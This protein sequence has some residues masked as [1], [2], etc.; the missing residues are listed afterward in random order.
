MSKLLEFIIESTK[1]GQIEK[2]TAV[3]AIKMLKAEEKKVAQDIAIIGMA[4]KLPLAGSFD[5][6]WDNI[7][8]TTDCIT[9]LPASRSRDIEAY[10]R[11]VGY[12][13]EEIKFSENAFLDEID[14]FDYR[15]FNISPKEASLMEPSQRVFLQVAWN[16]IEDAGY[17]GDMLAGTETAVFAGYASNLRDMYA[18]IIYDVDPTLASA[19]MVGNLPAVIPSRISYHLDLKGESVLLDTSCSSALVSV[20]FACRTLSEGLCEYAVAGGININTM[21][22]KSDNFKVGIESS[23]GRTR[24]FDDASDGSGIGEGVGAILLK[25]LGKALKDGDHIYAVI[26]GSA[27]NQDGSSAGITA[28]NPAA[29]TDVITKA[30][31]AAGIDPETIT[32]IETHGTGT[33][34][35]D[36]IEVKGIRG[37]FAKFTNKKQFCAISSVKTNLGHLCEAAGIISLIKAVL[38]LNKRQ[39]PPLK[40]F[41]SPNRNIDFCNSQVY[42]N[43]QTRTWEAAGETLRCGVSAFGISGTNCHVVLEEAPGQQN[44]INVD[45][46]TY[47]IFIL[48]AKSKTSLL[49]T[50]NSYLTQKSQLSHLALIDIC[51]TVA[52]GRGKYD[53]RIAIIA[54]TTDELFKKLQYAAVMIESDGL[55]SDGIYYSHSKVTSADQD[56]SIKDIGSKALDGRMTEALSIFKLNGSD[57][58]SVCD[59]C[60]YYV[61]GANAD[62][63]DFYSGRQCNRVSLPGY[64]FEKTR[65]WVNIPETVSDECENTLDDMYYSLVWRPSKDK[66]QK[67]PG[68][69]SDGG[70]TLVIKDAGGFGDKIISELR[71]DGCQIA[72]MAFG[73]TFSRLNEYE[74]IITGE[75]SDYVEAIKEL[76]GRKI[77]RII[78]MSAV[79][80]GNGITGIQELDERLKVGV[81]SLFYLVRA[82]L[83][84]GLTNDITLNIITSYANRVTGEEKTIDPENA[85]LIGFGKVIG[86]EYSNISVHA[87]DTDSETHVFDIVNEVVTKHSEYQCAYRRD[88]R[89][90]EEF[91]EVDIDALPDDNVSVKEGGVY[92]ITGGTGGIG[93]VSAR[94][95]ASK[96]RVNLVLISRTNLPPKDDWDKILS[97]NEDSRLHQTISTICRIE[98]E[99]SHVITI[100]T[101]VADESRLKEALEGVREEFGKIDGIIHG[102]GIAGAGYIVAKE[103]QV[104]RSVMRPKVQG[105]WLLDN[106]T[107]Q[108]KPDFF[109]MYSSGVTVSGEAGQGD[110]VAANSYMDS[111]AFYRS[112]IGKSLAINWVSWK[113]AGMSV[114]Y[115][116]NVDAIFKA[117][118]S[119]QATIG[120]GAV[121]GK[122]IPRILIGE[123]NNSPQYLSILTNLPFAL[124]QKISAA[125][126]KANSYSD[127]SASDGSASDGRRMI[128]NNGYTMAVVENGKIAFLPKS[129]REQSGL[130]K[131]RSVNKSIEYSDSSDIEKALERIYCEALGYPEVGIHD[132][133]FDLGGDSI[134][135]TRM[136]GDIEKEFAGL[137]TLTDLFAYTS[138]YSLTKFIKS[139]IDGNMKRLKPEQDTDS[140]MGKDIAIIG[141]SVRLPMADTLEEYWENI[142]NNVDCVGGL[143]ESR[144]RD[145]SDYYGYIDPKKDVRFSEGAYLNGIDEFDYSFFKL[146]P[147]E[148]KYMSPYQRIFME[149]V[150]HTVE[151]A[152]YAG[153]KIKGTKTGIYVGYAG[154]VRDSYIKMIYDTD[155][156]S[157]Q[158][159]MVGNIDAII[160]GRISYLLDIK[161]P[162]MVINTACSSALVCLHM[163]CGSIHNNECEM[164]LVSGIRMDL[165]SIY[166]KDMQIGIEAS[167]GRTRTFDDAADGSGMGEGFISILIKPLDKAVKDGDHIYAVIKGSAVNQDGTSIGLTAPNPASQEEVITEA[168]KNAGINPETIS[169]IE[170]HGT[171]TKLGDPIEVDGL[172][173]A[174]RQYTD[175]N[176]FCAISSIK[177]NMGHLYECSGLAGLVKGVLALKHRQIPPTSHFNRPNSIIDFCNSPVYV[178][179]KLRVWDSV[180][181][182]RRCSVSAFGLS[183]TNCHTVLEEYAADDCV[184]EDNAVMPGIFAISAKSLISLKLLIIMYME[185]LTD[186]PDV[187]FN[188]ICYSSL[189]SRDHHNFRIAII[190]VSKDELLQKLLSLSNDLECEQQNSFFHEHRVVPDNRENLLEKDITESQHIELSFAADDIIKSLGSRGYQHAELSILSEMYIRGADI[191]WEKL[192]AGLTPRKIRLP[193]YPFNENRC[194]IDIPTREAVKE[195]GKVTDEEDF[196][197][198]FQW[199]REDL[200]ERGI[201]DGD[202]R[203]IALFADFMPGDL[204][205]QLCCRLVA[206]GHTVYK[207]FRSDSFSALSEDSFAVGDKEEDYRRLITIMKERELTD[208]IHLYNFGDYM[209]TASLAD[210]NESLRRGF[211]SLFYL[212]RALA[213]G[214]S[215]RNINV[216]LMTDYAEE[217]TGREEI[218]KP[219]H[220]PLLG[221]GKVISKELPHIVCRAVDIDGSDSIG[222]ILNELTFTSDCYQTAYRDSKRYVKV[223]DGVSAV[224]D[225]ELPCAIREDGVYIITGGSGGIGVEIAKYLASVAKVRLAMVNRS[226]LPPREEWDSILAGNQG[227]KTCERIHAIRQ[228]EDMGAEVVCLKADCADISAM[229]QVFAYIRERFG[230]IN[231]VIHGAG[232][233]GGEFIVNRKEQD[234]LPIMAPKIQG[235]WVIDR[236]TMEDK[237]D[238]LVMF[239][240]IATIFHAPGQA[241]YVSA[242]AYMDAYAAYRTRRNAKT[243]TIKWST[244]KETGMSV[245]HKANF[246]TI[247]KAMYTN[248]AIRGF[249]DVLHSDLRNVLIGHANYDG[250]MISSMGKY[251]FRL[252][253]KI[254]RKIS[255]SVK[256]KK[257]ISKTR[258]R[259]EQ[260]EA[261]EEVVMTGRNNGTYSKMESTVANIWGDALGYSEIDINEHFFELGGD[262]IIGMKIVNAIVNEKPGSSVNVSG[263]LENP[264]IERFASYLEKILTS[265]DSYT[266][267]Y[268]SIMP[269]QEREYYPLSSEQTRMFVLDQMEKDSCRYNICRAELIKDEIDF[270][271]LKRIIERLVQ[272]HESLRTHFDYIDGEPVQIIQKEID[273][274]IELMEA[275]PASL[276]HIVEEFKRP[277]DISKAPL[278]RVGFVKLATGECLFI[279]DIHHI[280]TDGLSMEVFFEDF[281]NLYKEVELNVLTIQYKDYAIW[282]KAFLESEFI[283]RQ[284]EYWLGIFSDAVPVLRLPT[285]FKRP[286]FM[287]TDGSRVSK[288]LSEEETDKLNSFALGLDMTQFMIL[289]AAYNII[290]AKY[291][292]QEDIVIGTFV[293]GRPIKE[294]EKIMG[295]F[296]NTLALRNYPASEKNTMEFLYEVR[297]NAMNSYRNQDYQFDMLVRKLN[298]TGSGNRNPVFDAAFVLQ[299]TKS[300]NTTLAEINSEYYEIQENSSKFDLTLEV[301]PTG[302]ELKLV[303][304]YSKNLFRHDTAELMLKDYVSILDEIIHNSDKKI[305]ELR[306]ESERD[307]LLSEEE[308]YDMELSW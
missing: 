125:V 231:G 145:L 30:W 21:P 79:F 27:V 285:D 222:H 59:I 188:D 124:S 291:S 264:T 270:A 77:C 111:Y 119:A 55:R 272:R 31:K 210:L 294:V 265:T 123:I 303:F 51:H 267:D 208:I 60:E 304:E 8:C 296:V 45:K 140:G 112:S 278:F 180:E 211:Y 40:Y 151:D 74:F 114:R 2:E 147:N 17:G 280:I 235:T 171:G 207:V 266:C 36:P 204:G 190:A 19:G 259:H 228:L 172:T 181:H 160:P 10:M 58:S 71:R 94:Y 282:Q 213:M 215:G 217:V 298:M 14:C 162:S 252:S 236:L 146:S 61:C 286:K 80:D 241:G 49:N 157:M 23:D 32:Y 253:D 287:D 243:V 76:A 255:E 158:M 24:A 99:G 164:A 223:F 118:P 165:L 230:A 84:C 184:I 167:D 65:C 26:K 292:T 12:S 281:A 200:E 198:S 73:E 179:S 201:P 138:I 178:N 227:A 279:Y 182:P 39:L 288:M 89:Y 245:A 11:Y 205:E 98:E 220:A 196:F 262:S 176:Q 170:A 78:H 273:F 137:V 116:I 302:K 139:K 29:Q 122:A 260:R 305:G 107:R 261:F 20:H 193:L 156:G 72:S 206:L 283:K 38:A 135:L 258:T 177:S 120:L 189:V 226:S 22:Q 221:I 15:F 93:L 250:A 57:E 191:D 143:P 218:L 86:Q 46:S 87:V 47:E 90:I 43:T 132:S 75:E 13:E 257:L 37:A 242:N 9:R 88:V 141:I 187:C 194:W 104:F 102:A 144:K 68:I 159:S 7:C 249:S 130:V 301:I 150:W 297:R 5:E 52:T 133:F 209:D 126:T 134:I 4:A 128:N 91:R 219:F 149:N 33:N 62:W 131:G 183:G 308:T 142:K 82:I 127:S 248:D 197:F 263:L 240:S 95:L 290:L 216:L 251:A 109:I 225:A 234:F 16:A 175:K 195:T 289:L 96:A 199:V 85:A 203:V 161:G 70:I 108:D 117:I 41:N 101:D 34:L 299:N 168:W 81:Y 300:K 66:S 106:L 148:A 64:A 115:G 169:Y 53:Y 186:N 35:G 63:R 113:D 268:P 92:I 105:T 54:K 247:F 163:A 274:E 192:Y 166:E 185:F 254:E 276:S 202:E 83:K 173:R 56:A 110:Y 48:S 152:G 136:H 25:P 306:M 42:V 69:D 244:W 237:L 238:F 271:R 100:S 277:F 224:R 50:V 3:K 67:P 44:N 153:K 154:S 174:F 233:G 307:I 275:S 28:P 129:K 155:P 293:A 103:D 246:D 269:A 239:S 6:F 212:A 121:L 284:E 232:V 295:I 1:D 18:K 229:E 97:A 256:K 214:E